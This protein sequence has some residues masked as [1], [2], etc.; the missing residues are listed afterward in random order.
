MTLC[1][2]DKYACFHKSESIHFFQEAVFSSSGTSA[3][4]VDSEEF[5]KDSELSEVKFFCMTEYIWT[6]ILIT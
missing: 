1:S 2:I 5:V 4:F 6:K 3:D